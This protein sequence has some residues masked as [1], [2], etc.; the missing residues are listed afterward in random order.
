MIG[1]ITA[2]EAE[3][4]KKSSFENFKSI[5]PEGSMTN[6]EADDFWKSE[7]NTAANN[8]KKE[9]S[10]IVQPT[11]YFD[12][13]GKLFREGDHLLPD[14]NYEVNG[15]S[16]ETD[17]RGRIV[18]AEG[19]LRLRENDYDR[20]ME[21]VRN[22]DGQEYKERDERGHLI[23]HQFGGSDR[24]DNLVPMDAQLNHGDFVKL[25]KMLADAVK[26][27]AD[28]RFKVE[29]VYE[30]ESTR[31]SEFKVSY[32][33]DGDRETTVFRNERAE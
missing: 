23:G 15:Y 12:D 9:V 26:E 7:F 1:E 4:I 29:P 33:I 14:T 20:N 28:V 16:Y 5:Q 19:K 24:L 30:D 13:N 3:E 18:A 2:N 31:P 10:D 11:Q 6:A 17:D 8:A 21:N 27:N 32:S 22:M 25:E